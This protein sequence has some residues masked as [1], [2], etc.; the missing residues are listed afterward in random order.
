MEIRYSDS[1]NI[2]AKDLEELFLS[3]DWSSGRYPDKLAVAIAHSGTVITAWDGDKL[4]GLASAL[5]DSIMTAYIHYVLVN[6]AYQGKG[7][8]KGIMERISA[9]YKDYLRI[10]LIAYT[11]SVPFYKACGYQDKDGIP[12]NITTLWT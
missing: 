8:G 7:V 6:P 10:V 11:D 3:V 9:R 4:V 5:D 1:K 12:M 2:D